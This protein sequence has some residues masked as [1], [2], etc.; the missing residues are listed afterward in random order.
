[1]DVRA[2]RTGGSHPYNLRMVVEG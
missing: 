2:N 1:M